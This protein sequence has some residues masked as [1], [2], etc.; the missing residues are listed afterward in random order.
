MFG[1]ACAVL[2]FTTGRYHARL[3][4][5]RDGTRAVGQITAGDA[6]PRS[7][8]G[9]RAQWLTQHI[10]IRKRQIECV[11]VC[12]VVP[13]NCKQLSI[14]H[15]ALGLCQEE[16]GR[17]DLDAM[18]LTDVR[19]VRQLSPRLNVLPKDRIARVGEW[20]SEVAV[21]RTNTNNYIRAR[22]RELRRRCAPLVSQGVD[23]HCGEVVPQRTANVIANDDLRS[24]TRWCATEWLKIVARA[25]VL[26]LTLWVIMSALLTRQSR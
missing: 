1:P 26:A 23:S 12:N 13:F 11:Q 2:Q 9:Q 24:V 22:P 6:S 8:Y 3:L 14:R 4:T 21:N 10:V 15:F 5:D 25:V 20:H 19:S 16:A 17:Q 7:N 18:L